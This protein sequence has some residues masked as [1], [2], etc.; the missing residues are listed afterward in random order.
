ML[1]N[2]FILRCFIFAILLILKCMNVDMNIY[3]FKI[4]TNK[5]LNY[6]NIFIYLYYL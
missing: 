1:I 4:I 3:D 5:T 6:L 2:N